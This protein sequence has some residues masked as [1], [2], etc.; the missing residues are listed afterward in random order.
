MKLTINEPNN[1]ST[2]YTKKNFLILLYILMFFIFKDSIKNP[3]YNDVYQKLKKDDFFNKD[4]ENCNKYDPIFL[5]GER[6]KQF[7]VRICKS[8]ESY[9]ICYKNS[10]YNNYN[11]IARIKNGVICLSQNFILDPSKSV[12]TN[13]IFF[14]ISM[15]F[16]SLESFFNFYL[17]YLL[18]KK[19]IFF[20]RMN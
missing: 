11:K 12:Q 6:F 15:N 19:F 17:T 13:Y 1:R 8:D 10:K 5:M 7:P 14:Y 9:H 20:H 16:L 18:I 3:L 2:K 4:N